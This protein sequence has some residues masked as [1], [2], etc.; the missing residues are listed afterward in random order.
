M[1]FCPDYIRK[2]HDAY[3]QKANASRHLMFLP[4]NITK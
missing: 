3:V 2:G 4:A 1:M